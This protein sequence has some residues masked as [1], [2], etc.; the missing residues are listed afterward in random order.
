M[1]GNAV[2]RRYARAL[3]NLGQEAGKEELERYGECLSALGESMENSGKLSAVFSTPVVTLEE[4]KNVID[5]M[6]RQ[7]GAGDTER[8]F[9]ELLAGKDR[10]ALIPAIASDYKALLDEAEGISRGAVT[11]AVALDENRKA[12]IKQQLETQ[13]GRKLELVF[14]VDEAILGGLVLRIG[15]TVLDASLRTQLDNLKESIKRGE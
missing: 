9:C 1:I 6:L 10:L 3:F 11:T 13:T 15:D 5:A 2:S 14:A 7:V 4:K 8:R 12:S